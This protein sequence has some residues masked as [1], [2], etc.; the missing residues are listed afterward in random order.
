MTRFFSYP[1]IQGEKRRKS[2]KEDDCDQNGIRAAT[3]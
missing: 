1:K 2:A 3:H